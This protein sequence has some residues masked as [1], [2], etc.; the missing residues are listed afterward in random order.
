ML[1]LSWYI[2]VDVFIMVNM[3]WTWYSWL[4]L[5]LFLSLN[6]DDDRR[7]CH[8]PTLKLKERAK[9]EDSFPVLGP[10]LFNSMP[11]YIR[12]IKNC[13]PDEFKAGTVSFGQ[14]CFLTWTYFQHGS[15]IALSSTK[16]SITLIYWYLLNKTYQKVLKNIPKIYIKLYKTFKYENGD[17]NR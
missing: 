9:R 14:E 16:H 12:S 11:K 8:I 3:G 6:S 1:I 2:W 7:M 10:R 13:H 5:L 4:L 15:T 17:R